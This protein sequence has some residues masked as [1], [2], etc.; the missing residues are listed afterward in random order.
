MCYPHDSAAVVLQVRDAHGRYQPASAE[1]IFA[2][3]R[4]AVERQYAR[5]TAMSSPQVVREY[6]QMKLCGFPHEVFAMLL[7]DSQHRLMAYTELF[8][9]TI[10]AAS[11]YPRE[12]VK[13]VLGCNAA[14]VIFSHCHPRA[15][16]SRAR[17]TGS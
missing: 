3:A 13:E 12:V 6:L 4:Q 16:L 9:G 5:G 1:Q 2:A 10:D 8:R 11:V 7:L 14:A 17:P 15:C